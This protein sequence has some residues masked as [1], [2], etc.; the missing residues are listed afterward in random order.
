MDF[1]ERRSRRP[2]RPWKAASVVEK[3]LQNQ[4]SR[5]LVHYP[6]VALACVTRLIQDLVSLMRGQALVPEM[7]RQFRQ[8][9]QLR[10]EC[11]DLCSLR[12][13][14]AILSQRIAHHNAC[15][16][17]SPA[18][19]GQGAKVLAGVAPPFQRQYRLGGEA[20]FVGN[21]HANAL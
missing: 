19:A 8:F 15:D 13:D 16:L 10:R 6:A 18:K 12:S 4:S 3:R 21:S 2:L 20:Q 11:L 5:D 1:K 17:I 9:G 7:N 14:L